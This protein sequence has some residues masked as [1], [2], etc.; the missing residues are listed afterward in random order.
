[1]MFENARS[2]KAGAAAIALATAAWLVGAPANAND[3]VTITSSMAEF[4][5]PLLKDGF[6][7]WPYVN[8][9]A[10]KGG[11][12]VLGAFG[13]FDSF[14]T[15]I[16]KGEFPGSIGLIYDSLMVGSGNEIM[17]AYAQI[18]ETAEYPA[19][20]SWIAF[21]LRPEA[22]WSDGVP[23]TAHD[24]CFSLESVKEYG[25]PLLQ[26]FYNDV[27]S[28][29]AI[30]DHRV[31]Y[32]VATR[33]SM[34]PL[35]IAAGFTPS[36]R[37]FWEEEGID[38]TTLTPPPS[39]G[40]YEIAAVDPGRSITYRRVEDYWGKDLP[41]AK[42]TSNFDEIRYE[43]Y[44]DE[45]VMFE[46]FKAGEIDFRGEGS[47]KRWETEYDFTAI[48]NGDV[49]KEVF[50]DETPT[51]LH[52]LF[53]NLKRPKFQ[54][55]RVREA[56]NYLY[57]FEAVQRTLL[58]GK[59]QRV[60]SYFPNSEYGASGMPTPE[61]IA[62]LKPFEAELPSEVLSE[63]FKLPVTDGSGRIRANL[64]KAL[65]LFKEAGYELQNNRLMKDGRQLTF[66]IVTGSPE[67]ERLSAPFIKNL[68]RAGIDASIVVVDPAQWRSRTEQGEFDLYAAR[69]NFFPPPGTELRIY[70]GSDVEGDEGRGNKRGYANPVVD[71]LIDQ[72][73]AAKDLEI[74]QTTTRALDRVL[75]W[76]HTVIPLYFD[77][78]T[79]VAYW[80]KFGRP[81]E[82]PKYATGFPSTWWIDQDLEQELAAR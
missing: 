5:E 32:T 80:N 38:K 47:A 31:K 60:L 50:D 1:M 52:A 22:A 51:G 72:I 45:T 62:I 27:T 46:A 70:F 7:H 4:G 41:F 16:L 56:I 40:A 15:V 33:D 61:E 14:N 12:I 79:W 82:Q 53:F 17:S 11:K 34:K 63:E 6:E 49:V 67:T 26:S 37:H 76:E 20:K 28:C 3:D 54:D 58:Y 75:L 48:D 66:E 30:D 25:R 77:D 42:G 35:M 44:K 78:E 73:V 36:P 74:L 10:P 43:Y 2:R 13:S 39:S 71:T 81:D 24:F 8:P 19:D 23:I 29:E 18:A 55:V 9:D 68:R 65:A 57:D 64:R 59:Y 69:N 21:N